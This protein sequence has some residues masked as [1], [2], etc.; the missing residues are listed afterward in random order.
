[1]RRRY[2]RSIKKVFSNSGID[3]V[4]KNNEII[5]KSAKSDETQQP[6]PGAKKSEIVG[7]VIDANTGESIIGASV[8]IKGA[9]TGVITNIDGKFTIMASPSDVIIISY[10]GY[11]PKEIKIGSHKVL[12]IELIE[13]AKQLE[14]VVVTAYGTGQ[15]KPVWSVQLK[16][17][18]RQN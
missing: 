17:S 13:D 18:N 5:L 7:V 1:M 6:K 14:E 11:T 15:R 12:S 8:Q 9:A 3:Y 16:R 10:V 4:I 2:Q